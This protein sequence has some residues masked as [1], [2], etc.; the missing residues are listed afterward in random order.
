MKLLI[1]L[2]LAILAGGYFIWAFQKRMRLI[3]SG[4]PVNRS[5]R[6][7]ERWRYFAAQ[8]L[9][10]KKIG[11]API[12]GIWHL[13]LSWGFLVLLGSSLAMLTTGLF[14]LQLPFVESNPVY[15]FMRDTALALVMVA[16]FGCLLRRSIKKPE[17][18]S[19]NTMSYVILLLVLVI[20]ISEGLFNAFYVMNTNCCGYS[21]G[22]S[23]LV[24]A[25]VKLLEDLPIRNGYRI[26]EVFWWLHFLAMF[27]FAVIIPN[28]KHLHLIFAPFNTYWHSLEPQGVL[29]PVV[30]DQD[31]SKGQVYGAG[32]P[33]DFTWKQLL[34][35]FS[36]V[37]CGRCNNHCP[38][39]Q[40]NEQTKPKKLNGRL[41]KHLENKTGKTLDKI[42]EK[43]AIWGC[44]TCGGCEEVCPVSC[45]P[46]SK[47]I[48][49]RRYIV[50]GVDKEKIPEAI[51]RVFA[52][53][54]NYG[55]PWGLNRKVSMGYERLKA[56]GLP[57][58]SENSR[59]EYL[60]FIGCAA[61]YEESALQTA[62]AFGKILSQAGVNIAIL[63]DEEFCCGETVRRMGNERLFQTLVQANMALWAKWGVKKIVTTCPHC[64]HTLQNEYRQFG[65]DYEVIPHA[66]FLE[67]LLAEGRIK[68]RGVQRQ[69]RVVAYHDSCYL[70]RHN[71]Y[72]QQPRRVLQAVPGVSL[73]EPLRAKENSFCC[74]AGGGRFWLKEELPNLISPNR[75][76][77]ILATGAQ[78][79]CTSCPYCKITLNAELKQLVPGE[80]LK[81]VDIAE[82]L[83]ASL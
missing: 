24:G 20:V 30:F 35:V 31:E 36:C 13:F 71:G 48:D 62:V 44:T 14:Q 66:A 63:E 76:K 42:F 49:M 61:Y 27:T 19:G 3:R 75:A 4:R 8:V 11:N 55:S 17:W 65:G 81:V 12:F 56:L 39:R 45:E 10:Q 52:G 38:A 34:D 6:P 23:W 68:S 15:L 67:R 46:I 33:E 41:R 80:E 32:K 29:S 37:K 51:K 57:A 69:P 26:Q 83:A 82:V 72:Y 40:S 28:S 1:F 9:R 64:L 22:A 60:Y 5:D 58:L 18:L 70:G 21:G 59:A 47:Y 73:A 25:T 77:E 79:F 50:A 7:L 16:V 78:A 43:E 2:L 53:C 74:G 54:E